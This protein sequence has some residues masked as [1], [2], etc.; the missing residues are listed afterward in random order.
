MTD[1]TFVIEVC[2]NCASHQWNTRHNEEKYNNYFKMMATAII[3]RMPNAIIMRNQ[4]PKEYVNYDCYSNLVPNED[5]S[6]PY[7]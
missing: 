2:Q 3:S 7:F 4:I 6:N 5:P 1:P